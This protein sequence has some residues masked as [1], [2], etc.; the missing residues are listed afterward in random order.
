MS[1][2]PEKIWAN[3]L[4]GEMDYALS[5]MID[6]GYGEQYHNTAQLIEWLEGQL[7]GGKKNPTLQ[8]DVTIRGVIEYLRDKP[9][10]E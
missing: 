9:D 2:M 8:H 7:T 10:E 1:D 3:R 4:T 6:Y 5:E